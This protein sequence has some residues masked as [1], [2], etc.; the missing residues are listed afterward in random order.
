MGDGNAKHIQCKQKWVV[1]T[2]RSIT[3][4]LLMVFSLILAVALYFFIRN[5]LNRMPDA[6]SSKLD[7]KID[8]GVSAKINSVAFT[9][10]STA[11]GGTTVTTIAM[12]SAAGAP[13]D[14][15]GRISPVPAESPIPPATTSGNGNTPTQPQ[16]G[17]S[18]QL[19]R[20][21]ARWTQL[22]PPSQAC[23]SINRTMPRGRAKESCK[24]NVVV[25]AVI[26]ATDD[27]AK[28][29]LRLPS[30]ARAAMHARGKPRKG[31]PVKV[32]EALLDIEDE[33]VEFTDDGSTLTWKGLQNLKVI[34]VVGDTG[35]NPKSGADVR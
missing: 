7:S 12:Q 14:T 10:P 28:V 21:H 30:G 33:E 6:V 4:A 31:F 20:I 13:T 25:R 22:I 8:Q 18:K 9:E 2:D 5:D 24:P 19:P 29:A 34:A 27:C 32:C 23:G 35:C 15:P 17:G 3:V 16:A 26:D 11:G 1:Y